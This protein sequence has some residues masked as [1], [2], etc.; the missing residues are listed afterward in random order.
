MNYEEGSEYSIGDRDGVT[1]SGL[2]EMGS[3]PV[4][5]GERDLAA[6]SDVSNTAVASGSGD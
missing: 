2:V 1:D 3:S 5:R 4:T 6:E